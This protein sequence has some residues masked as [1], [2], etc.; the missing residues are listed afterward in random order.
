MFSNRRMPASEAYVLQA[1]APGVIGFEVGLT[2]ESF[3]EQRTKSWTMLAYVV[4][5]P[6]VDRPH[7]VS[8]SPA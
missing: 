7:L 8:A 5:A 3:Y 2:V 6:A 4:P 1:Q